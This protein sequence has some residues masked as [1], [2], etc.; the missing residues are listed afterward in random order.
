MDCSLN[1]HSHS[2][3][4]LHYLRAWLARDL[5]YSPHY[6]NSG[7]RI[8]SMTFYGIRAGIARLCA[9]LAMCVGATTGALAQEITVYSAGNVTVGQTR[10]LT[11]Y[12][13]LSPNGV[14]WGR[15]PER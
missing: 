2:N 8:M 10:Q 12:V 4:Q 5:R 7:T 1:S 14:S 15:S 13:P 6:F 3:S 11:G 9:V